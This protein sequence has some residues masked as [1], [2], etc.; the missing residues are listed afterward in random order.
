MSED[1]LVEFHG[2]VAEL[3]TRLSV[4]KTE[5]ESLVRS[6]EAQIKGRKYN[7]VKLERLLEITDPVLTKHDLIV[8]EGMEMIGDYQGLCMMLVDLTSGAWIKTHGRMIPDEPGPRAV[9]TTISYLRRYMRLSI[10]GLAQEDDDAQT[11]A[12]RG[13]KEA[14]G[15]SPATVA[16]WI[17]QI[18]EQTGGYAGFV[19][20]WKTVPQ[21][22]KDDALVKEQLPKWKEKFPPE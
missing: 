20:L 21:E 14:Q 4:A 3:L 16:D 10:L 22:V 17:K 9:G 12:D 15:A 6:E 8:W 1:F 19:K 5:F 18:D 13:E 7:Y 2:K 11:R